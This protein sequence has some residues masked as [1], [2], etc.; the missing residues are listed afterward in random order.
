MTFFYDLNK[1]LDS[2]REKP[3]VTHKQLNERDMSRVAKGIEKYGKD[4]MQALAKAGREGKDLDKIRDKYDKYDDKVDEGSTGDYSAKK[5]RAGKDIGKPGKAFSQIAKSAGERYGSKERGEKVAGAVLAKLRHPKEDVEEGM[6][7]TVKTIGK[8]VA[9][10]VNKLVGH[11]SDEEMRKD[12]QRKAGV[13]PTGKKPEQQVKEKLSP[14]KQKSF[15]ALAPPR[16]KI[17]LADKIAGA[18]KEFDEMLGDVAAEAMR[19][20]VGGGHGRNA[21]MVEEKSKGTAFDLSA[22]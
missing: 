1:K 14:A 16:D 17:T 21:E 10:G 11:G 15:A 4:G 18:K 6:M 5:A 22:P 7:D 13:P 20:A 12:L 19:K 8:K 2:I 9:S 3:E